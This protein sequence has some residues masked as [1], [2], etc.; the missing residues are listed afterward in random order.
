MLRLPGTVPPL[1][2]AA[3]T[4]VSD[5][6]EGPD[7]AGLSHRETE[8]IWRAVERWYQS[9]TCPAIALCIRRRG[10]V[11]LDRSIGLARGARGGREE[12]ATPDTLFNIFSASK[13]VVGVLIHQA[14]SRGEVSLDAPIARYVPEFAQNGKETITI[15]DV[16]SHR[17]G[18]PGLGEP[19]TLD[20]LNDRER[21]VR[22]LCSTKPKLR[23]GRLAYHALSGGYILAEVLERVTGLSIQELLQRDIS[24]PLGLS[25]FRF[26]A[27]REDHPRV[28]ENV[29][30]GARLPL[31]LSFFFR[32]A[33]GI[34]AE[35]AT[36]LSNDPRF[37][38]AVIPAGNLVTSASEACLFMDMLRR[39]AAGEEQGLVPPRLLAHALAQHSHLELD[40]T[41][42][43]PVSYGLGFMLGTRFFSSYG[44]NTKGVFGHLG[45]LQV[46]LWSDPA[47][48]LSGAMLTSGKSFLSSSHFHFAAVMQTIA[49]QV[50]RS[51]DVSPRRD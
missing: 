37:C 39:S 41:L 1:D 4:R 51:V 10:H 7:A 12:I 11:I 22:W 25:H 13:M 26:G 43:L 31:P 17:S 28:A 24:V 48:E 30:T 9:G 18:L 36:R 27:A 35:D 20:L 16:L 33:L 14:R 2:S 5:R 42:I 6:E 32:R 3:V 46:L 50:E 8:A 15:R 23:R 40:S 47:R 21:I 45:F 49:R 44:P 34:S 29:F 19:T 38:D